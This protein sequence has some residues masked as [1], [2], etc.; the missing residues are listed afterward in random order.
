[1]QSFWKPPSHCKSLPYI[2]ADHAKTR[3]KPEENTL[4][5]ELHGTRSLLVEPRF[6]NF[7]NM[8]AIK[9][10]MYEVE[11]SNHR[12]SF[13]TLLLYWNGKSLR[14]GAN[15]MHRCR[16]QSA[17]Y[18]ILWPSNHPSA[19]MG[20]LGF[21]CSIELITSSSKYWP[22]AFLMSSALHHQHVQH[23]WIKS[24]WCNKLCFACVLGDNSDHLQPV[25]NRIHLCEKINTSEIMTTSE[26]FP[27]A[28]RIVSNWFLWNNE[29]Y[30]HLQL[31]LPNSCNKI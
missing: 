9:R 17:M 18:D 26:I 10:H 7:A 14:Q 22:W 11:L 21:I 30:L 12:L 27:W 24:P 23:N 25:C 19:A 28:T 15:R 3:L 31:L 29:N 5:S 1:L 4:H 13:K 8:A 20:I 2:Y 6:P 16:I